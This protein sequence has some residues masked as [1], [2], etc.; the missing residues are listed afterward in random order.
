MFDD[1]DKVL[2]QIR[3]APYSL[4]LPITHL[5]QYHPQPQLLPSAMSRK[6]VREH[7]TSPKFHR[8][9]WAEKRTRRGTVFTAEVTAASGSPMTPVKPKKHTAL[10]KVKYSQDQTPISVGGIEAAMSLPPIPAPGILAPK[11]DRRG[12]V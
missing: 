1:C 11:K 7:S 8:V 2:I 4:S 12:K 10:G 5:Y 6:R 3:S 9:A